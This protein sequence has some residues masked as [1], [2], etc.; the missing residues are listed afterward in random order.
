MKLPETPSIVDLGRKNDA[1]ATGAV[2]DAK[3]AM[4]YHKQNVTNTES[5]LVM[6]G[7]SAIQMRVS[8]SASGVVEENA[9]MQFSISIMDVDTGAV[10]AGSIDIDS[11]SAVITKSTGGAAFSAS[12]I[13]VITFAK[14]DGRVYVDY[15]FLADEWAT[16]DVYRIIV[17]GIEATI[18]G[19]VG[20]VP[21]MV[22]TN[23]VGEAADV[24]T[25]VDAIET[26]ITAYPTNPGVAQICTTTE[27][28]NQGAGAKD[29]FTGSAQDVILEGFS[30]KMPTEAA[31]G[32]ITSISVQTD[33][34][35]PGL[36]LE[37]DDLQVAVLLSEA[38]FSWEGFML[39]TVG[40]K[41]QLTIAGGAHGTTYTTKITAKVRANAAGGTLV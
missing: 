8:Q 5:I 38:E 9:Y 11:I 37:A 25:S 17:S 18:G 3:S 41:I 15:Q 36:I 1:A 2:S 20:Y 14:D 4:A 7:G 23:F 10:A 32:S 30:I 29:L 12:G 19:D 26:F 6:L 34:E 13:T 28:L 21:A 27:D 40:T 31:G 24:K 35:S 33:D 39:I 16:G 22:W